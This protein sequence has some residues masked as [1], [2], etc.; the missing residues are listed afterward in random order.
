MKSRYCSRCQSVHPIDKP[1]TVRRPKQVAIFLLLTLI[2]TAS[3]AQSSCAD[4]TCQLAVA[5]DGLRVLLDSLFVVPAV[6]ELRTAF[7]AGVSIPL[8]GA[9]AAWSVRMI[10]N[11]FDHD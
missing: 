7:N 11:Q 2:S 1:C 9:I 4:S 8:V 3:M 6:T 10:L 5:V